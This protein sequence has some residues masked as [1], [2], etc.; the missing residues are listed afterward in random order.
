VTTSVVPFDA[1]VSGSQV[2]YTSNGGPSN[3]LA[4]GGATVLTSLAGTAVT[5]R[6]PSVATQM[7]L[8][9]N[10]QTGLGPAAGGS[11][12]VDALAG[13][14]SSYGIKVGSLYT[15]FSSQVAEIGH[16]GTR[17]TLPVI[18]NAPAVYYTNNITAGT[19]GTLTLGL[20]GYTCPNGDN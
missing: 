11:I 4:A 15:L 5:A 12:V 1:A 14:A 3:I 9:V 8:S 20:V 18:N 17:F 13:S 7:N 2:S 16:G 6:V 10:L 19:S